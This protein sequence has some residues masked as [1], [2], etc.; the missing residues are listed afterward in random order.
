MLAP[1]ALE[2]RVAQVH[3]QRQLPTLTEAFLALTTAILELRKSESVVNYAN[4]KRRSWNE[5]T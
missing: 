4:L 3:G 1:G 5:K 2:H